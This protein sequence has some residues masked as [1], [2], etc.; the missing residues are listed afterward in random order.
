[1]A[2]IEMSDLPM[3][4]LSPRKIAQLDG[5]KKTE[6]LEKVQ[7]G[8]VF[9]NPVVVAAAISAVGAVIREF[10]KGFFQLLREKRQK[11]TYEAFSLHIHNTHFHLADDTAASVEAEIEKMVEDALRKRENK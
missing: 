6:C 8:G 11:G 1:M 2:L 9:E 5:V 10:L 3:R 7:K 4:N